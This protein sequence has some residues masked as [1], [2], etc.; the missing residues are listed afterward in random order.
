MSTN[1]VIEIIV[2]VAVLAFA[3]ILVIVLHRLV[4]GHE[5]DKIFKLESVGFTVM[6]GGL[7]LKDLWKLGVLI[8]RHDPNSQFEF[9]YRDL[10][11]IFLV[12][13]ASAALYVGTKVIMKRFDVD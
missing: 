13:V 5:T 6:L 7:L 11:E 8:F 12:I 4:T 10:V 2:F 1:D 3:A 9:G